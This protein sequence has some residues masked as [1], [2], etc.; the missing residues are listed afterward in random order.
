MKIGIVGAGVAGLTAAYRLAKQGHEIEIFRSFGP[1]GGPSFRLPSSGHYLGKVL[2]PSFHERY[3]HPRPGGRTGD[4]G[5]TPLVHEFNGRLSQRC[6]VFPCVTQRPS[7][8]QAPS[9]LGKNMV[10]FPIGFLLGKGK[11]LEKIR[12]YNSTRLDEKIFGAQH[13][14]SYVGTPFKGKIRTILR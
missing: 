2:S 12:S 1:R 13:L 6:H 10:W 9:F 4:A 14:E 11:K 7:Y 5:E 3:L 8:F